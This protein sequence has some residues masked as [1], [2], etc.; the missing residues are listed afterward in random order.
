MICSSFNYH[1]IITHV[2]RNNAIYFNASYI[3]DLLRISMLQLFL[4]HVAMSPFPCCNN[5]FS[6]LQWFLFHVAMSPFPCCNDSF[7]MLQWF[8][9]Q[10]A[11]II[12]P[13]CNNYFSMLQ[14]SFF[15]VAI[16]LVTLKYLNSYFLSSP[17]F[18]S[19]SQKVWRTKGECTV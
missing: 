6:M 18:T 10:D 4:F 11:I 15:Y 9:F 5:S 16:S 7:S 1:L 12:F 3:L 13:G 19:S 8:L 17:R 2:Y 14:Q